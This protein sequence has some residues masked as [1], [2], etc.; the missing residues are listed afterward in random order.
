MLFKSSSDEA[1]TNA[2]RQIYHSHLP[3]SELVPQMCGL[4]VFID[5]KCTESTRMLLELLNALCQVDSR[6]DRFSYLSSVPVLDFEEYVKATHK[7][8]RRHNSHMHFALNHRTLSHESFMFLVE[9][10]HLMEFSRALVQSKDVTRDSKIQAF[11]S[12][13]EKECTYRLERNNHDFCNIISESSASILIALVDSENERHNWVPSADAKLALE[14][15][16]RFGYFELARRLLGCSNPRCAM[17]LASQ[18]G[19]QVIVQLLMSDAKT[20][21][22]FKNQHSSMIDARVCDNQLLDQFAA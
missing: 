1:L 13:V 11:A 7:W 21:V 6:T 4:D 12:V 20:S 22:F 5:Q 9:N 17:N 19:H 3:I 15:A 18:Y 2:L 10:E 16:C 8:S 14:W